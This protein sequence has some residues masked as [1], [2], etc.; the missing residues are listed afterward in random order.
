[1]KRLKHS[2]LPFIL[3]FCLFLSSACTAQATDVTTGSSAATPAT[4]A[5]TSAAKVDLEQYKLKAIFLHVGSPLI[6]SGNSITF[7]DPNDYD[8]AATI[9]NRRT[10]VPLRALA[11]YFD[12]RVNYL[13]AEKVAVIEKEGVI[14]R[15][16]IGSNRYTVTRKGKTESFT[17]DTK[18]LIMHQR[19]MVPLRV[20]AE[21]LL[22]KKVDYDQG[23]ISISDP[24]IDLAGTPGLTGAVKERIGQALKATSK[25]ALSQ[26]MKKINDNSFSLYGSD[27][28]EEKSAAPVM[29]EAV[30]DAAGPGSNSAADYSSTNTQVEGIDEADIVKTDG[31]YLYC[32]GGNAVRIVKAEDAKLSEAAA[33]KYEESKWVQEIYVDK[34]RLI[35]LG[36][37][38]EDAFAEPRPLAEG[39][40]VA[41]TD[42]WPGSASKNF[43][44][45]DVYDISDPAAP[46]LLKTHEMEGCYQTSRKSGDHLYL[47][48]ESFW[49]GPVIPYMLDS[50]AGKQ[51]TELPIKDI[52][53]MPCPIQPGYLIL[54]AIN[55]RNNSH[56][57]VEAIT[58]SGS[59]VYMNETALYIATAH[60]DNH[61]DITKFKIDGMNIGYAGSG[62]VAGY[63]KNQFGMDEYQG[64]LRIATTTWEEGNNIFVLDPSMTTIGSLAGLAEGETIYATRFMGD[65]A[66]VVTFVQTDPLFVLDMSDPTAPRVTGE[67]KVPGFSNYLHPIA[68]DVLLGI[69]METRTLI[70]RDANGRE[71][72]V[73]VRTGGIKLSL[74]DVSDMGKPRELTSLTV[75]D[76]GAHT[77]ALD[78]HKAVMIDMAK[79]LVAFHANLGYFDDGRKVNY[80][81]TKAGALVFSFKDNQLAQKA[82]LSYQ[83]P[84][85]Y[86]P[87]IPYGTRTVYIGSTLYYVQDGVIQAFDY[88]DFKKIGEF[89]IK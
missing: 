64:N 48:T 30:A 39:A 70:E 25:T 73:G 4:A 78:N 50:T 34:D 19:T 65:K 9:Y 56:V 44:F 80:E 85:V 37:R 18:A 77:E 36:N 16:S 5:A 32:A 82:L 57:E 35:V 6:L 42:V 38:H 29:A 89:E 88:N 61:T 26:L 86:G 79:G 13:K 84:K 12:A 1:M 8:V 3:A 45:A 21:K 11:E 69:G 71:R 76:S 53:V 87:F 66:Y 47:V 62:Q 14:F 74:F 58:A 54:S 43:S 52:M 60:S 68:N 67:L 49:S 20:V 83:K 2:Y 51:A 28:A 15:F 46:E 23:V 72:E 41:T 31:R 59:I 81:D 63:M 7:L 10:L 24:T 40:K 22:N 33:I 55:V 27:A 75:G 17:M